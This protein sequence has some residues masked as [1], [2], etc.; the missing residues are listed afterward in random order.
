MGSDFEGYAKE[1]FDISQKLYSGIGIRV[2]IKDSDAKKGSYVLAV[3]SLITHRPTSS[4]PRTM[5][6]NTSGWWS[7]SMHPPRS[8]SV[9]SEYVD[10]KA[11]SSGAAP[12]FDTASEQCRAPVVDSARRVRAY[13]GDLFGRLVTRCSRMK[14]RLAFHCRLPCT[15]PSIDRCRE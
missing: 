8:I 14:A 13:P 3:G 5:Y 9:S 6:S 10:C 11:I 15:H 7:L 12:G 2:T 1:L 4:L